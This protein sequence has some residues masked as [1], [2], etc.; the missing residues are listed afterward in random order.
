MR[1]NVMSYLEV[2]HDTYR[3]AKCQDFSNKPIG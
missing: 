1:V 3:P 2:A